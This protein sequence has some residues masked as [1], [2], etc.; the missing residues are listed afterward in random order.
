MKLSISACLRGALFAFG[1][2][3]L[4]WVPFLLVYSHYEISD[5]ALILPVLVGL[6]AIP[7]YFCVKGQCKGGYGAAVLVS[8][9]FMIV[10]ELMIDS[11][12]PGLSKVFIPWQSSFSLAGIACLYVSA[13]MGAVGTF[14]S[15]LDGAICLVRR[16]MKGR[17]F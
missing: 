12:I 10:L 3:L 14:V 6:A 13:I 9:I 5:Y 4:S 7:L 15:L 8:N 16:L 11:A 1:Y 2:H 17:E